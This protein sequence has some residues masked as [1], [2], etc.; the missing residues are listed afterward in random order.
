MLPYISGLRADI[1]AQS[2]PEDRLQA[3]GLLESHLAA[4]DG[5]DPSIISGETLP[6]STRGVHYTDEKGVDRINLNSDLINQSTPFQA[7]ETCFH[8]DRHSHQSLVVQHPE[9]AENQQQLNDWTMSSK[10][11][12]IQPNEYDH[13]TYRWQ[14]T[15]ADSNN[16]AR[17]STDDLYQNTFHD[18]QQYPGYKVS[19]EQEVADDIAD[20]QDKL[21]ENYEETARQMMVNK[22]QSLHPDYQQISSPDIAQKTP[23]KEIAP[24]PKAAIS[25]TEVEKPEDQMSM[26]GATPE[27][28][29]GIETLTTKEPASLEGKETVTQPTPNL[30]NE[31]N[32]RSNTNEGKEDEPSEV[33]R[34]ERGFLR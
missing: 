11:G 33:E 2:S 10:D 13:A 4:K 29:A 22:F 15:E 21:G 27:D 19:K 20:A 30:L 3:L 9:K 23:D 12:Y 31:G 6:P 32:S 17:A 16:A 1:W 26:P 7:V 8:E 25:Q 34:Y 18:T 28:R 24:N 14:P 5:R